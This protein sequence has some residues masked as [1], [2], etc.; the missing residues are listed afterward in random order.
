MGIEKTGKELAYASQVKELGDFT[1]ELNKAM[2]SI[3][4][5]SGTAKKELSSLEDV[6]NEF[7]EEPAKNLG[8]LIKRF[9]DWGLGISKTAKMVN[10][11]ADDI[12]ALFE[13]AKKKS[14]DLQTLVNG[15]KSFNK[16]LIE[17]KIKGSDAGKTFEELG[18][19][20]KGDVSETFFQAAQKLRSFG[21]NLDQTDY[22]LK[23]FGYDGFAIS[24][25]FD[26]FD[27]NL[28][29]IVDR[30]K[31]LGLA[32]NDADTDKLNQLKE[33]IT[34]FDN[35]DTSASKHALTDF[36]S[37]YKSCFDKS[38][39]EPLV[40]WQTLIDAFGSKS[41]DVHKLVKGEF[42]EFKNDV[43]QTTDQIYAFQNKA[44]LQDPINIE[45]LQ[46]NMLAKGADIQKTID[47]FNAL[48][49]I[50]TRIELFMKNIDTIGA[51]PAQAFDKI[52]ESLNKARY[53]FD[54]T[55]ESMYRLASLTE[56]I[57][58]DASG[59]QTASDNIKKIRP[60][61]EQM[62]DLRDMSEIDDKLKKTDYGTTYYTN[63]YPS[64]YGS[65]TSYH[66]DVD[67]DLQPDK[68]LTS[69]WREFGQNY[70][71]IMRGACDYVKETF[72]STKSFIGGVA[73]DLGKVFF[74]FLDDIEN[75][76]A[77]AFYRMMAQ[78]QSFKKSMSQMWDEIKDAAMKALSSIAAKMIMSLAKLPFLKE[79]GFASMGGG[80][81]PKFAKGGFATGKGLPQAKHGLITRGTG[82]IPAIL[83]PDEV[84]LPIRYIKQFFGSVAERLFSNMS[85]PQIQSMPLPAMAASKP[86]KVVNINLNIGAGNFDNPAYWRNLFR[87][88]IK[89]AMDEVNYGRL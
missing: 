63:R 7:A 78:G 33:S 79:G 74:D 10:M 2:D 37:F 23:M 86:S 51:K 60:D 56:K 18:L 61:E 65:K 40:K 73:A 29:T 49:N 21:D 1:R 36:I 20:F 72:R 6:F 5:F 14:V 43:N 19:T 68:E 4:I 88:K 82:I 16:F 66:H 59:L 12:S 77:G 27:D 52:S 17:T 84:V 81:L 69:K 75:A 25:L 48:Q 41:K 39:S 87:T 38:L 45:D 83:H 76:L 58:Y 13:V 44:N 35:P 28:K 15:L 57:D 31:A 54:K 89:P 42:G 47:K 64:K 30:I 62:S 46:E 9:T 67:I 34:S 8:L 80:S 55:N 71:A 26:P 3:K 53:P 32:I 22:A 24:N 70:K 50:K 11:S 85:M